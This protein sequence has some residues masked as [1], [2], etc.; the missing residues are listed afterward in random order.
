MKGAYA[1]LGLGM[2][3]LGRLSDGIRLGYATGF[4]S[5]TMV[6]YVY[7]N[8]AH[9]IT[10]LGRLFDRAFLDHPVWEGVRARRKLLVAQLRE[11]LARYAAPSLFDVAAGPGSYLFE[12]PQGDHWAGDIM[13]AEVARGAARATQAARPDIHFV[14]ADAFDPATWPRPRFDVLVSSGFFDILTDPADLE[15]LL[16]AG[17]RGTG[18][19]ARWVWTVMERHTNLALL[20]ATTI[21][22][23]KRPWVATVRPA[24]DIGA[25]AAARGWRLERTEREP[26]GFFAVA[27]M[28]RER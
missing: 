25:L 3:T 6:D 13:P 18:V 26:G 17:T 8:E 4:D 5:G 12:L 11:A 22:F 27:T 9:G 1:A 24:D 19:G 23:H 14:R 16:D 10:P 21:D 7:R 15:R 28:V 20:E 2:R